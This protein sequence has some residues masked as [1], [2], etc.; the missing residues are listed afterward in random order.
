MDKREEVKRQKKVKENSNMTTR[1]FIQPFG[2]NY[3]LLSK[4]GFINTYLGDIDREPASDGI[5]LYFLFKP[6]MEQEKS[7][8]RYGKEKI[9]ESE[10]ELLIKKIEELE[11]KDPENRVYVEDY[12][13][14]GGYIIL[15]LRLPKELEEDYE[16]FLNGEY[17]KFSEKFRKFF[18]KNAVYDILD[19]NGALAKRPGK[20]YQYM[21]IHKE[22]E[23]RHALEEHFGCTFEDDQELEGLWDEE[24]DY[25][26]ISKF[27]KNDGG[28]HQDAIS[29]ML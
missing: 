12:D 25:L 17:S 5:L 28:N 23:L 15:V 3:A 27:Y 4:Y 13:Y 8:D 16:K 26:D 22:P 2:F 14:E 1:Y 18:P 21:V 19:A 29:K 6:S 7:I 10:Y 24:K 9:N 11:E 20:S